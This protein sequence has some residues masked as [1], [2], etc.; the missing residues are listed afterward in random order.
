M[1][2]ALALGGRTR[3]DHGISTRSGTDCTPS[4]RQRVVLITTVF[5]KHPP[6]MPIFLRTAGHSGVDIMMF[7]DTDTI[8]GL[9]RNVRQIFMTWEHLVGLV[10][11]RMFDGRQL[12]ELLKANRY[13]VVDL[14]P[15]YGFLFREHIKAYEFW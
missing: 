3:N 2:A 5:G 7:G 1:A 11:T 14:K 12:P 6:Y 9:P 15:A 13:K 4:T 10:S 8:P